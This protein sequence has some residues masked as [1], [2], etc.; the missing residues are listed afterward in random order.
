MDLWGRV[1]YA[2]IVVNGFA[3]PSINDPT[4]SRHAWGMLAMRLR[5]RDAVAYTL[6][7]H[8][9]ALLL[10]GRNTPVHG[11][12]DTAVDGRAIARWRP[13]VIATMVTVGVV[14]WQH[15]RQG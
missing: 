6:A 9:G 15:H 7:M 12:I 3:Q 10:C 4:H 2:V 11:G 8:L 14:A 1:A 13:F 5:T